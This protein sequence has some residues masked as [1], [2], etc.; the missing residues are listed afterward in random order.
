VII[1]FTGTRRGMTAAQAMTIAGDIAS[2]RENWPGAMTLLH[3]DCV[4]ADAEIHRWWRSAFGGLRGDVEV[5]RVGSGRLVAMSDAD[6][7]FERE[8]HLSRN[9]EIVERSTLLYG[10]PPCAEPQQRG[11]TWYTIKYAWRQGKPTFVVAPD[12]SRIQG[13]GGD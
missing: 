7:V 10:A 3:G 13:P 4:G 2:M 8:S 5:Y 9:R 12:G 6:R 1:G 11:G